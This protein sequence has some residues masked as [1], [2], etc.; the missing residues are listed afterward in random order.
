MSLRSHPPL[1]PVEPIFARNAY[2]QRSSKQLSCDGATPHTFCIWTLTYAPLPHISTPPPHTYIHTYIRLRYW[3]AYT[4][5][6]FKLYAN[7]NNYIHIFEFILQLFECRNHIRVI[8][9]MENG[10]RLYICGTNAHNPKDFVV[11]VSSNS[12]QTCETHTHT[13]HTHILLKYIPRIYAP[14]YFM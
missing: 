12:F 2:T 1:P 14:N 9:S 6:D 11:N 4:V 13:H 10:S 3:R 7:Y 8:Q 5:H